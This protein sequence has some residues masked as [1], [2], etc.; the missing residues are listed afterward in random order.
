M[1]LALEGTP[2]HNNAT[3]GSSLTTGAFTTS[4]AA[5]VFIAVGSNF[6][7]ANSVSSISGG[8][9]TWSRR[10]TGGNAVQPIELWAAQ[11]GS[12]LSG[13][14]FTLTYSAAVQFTTVDVFA[15]SGQ[16]TSTI[17]DADAS[18]PVNSST[19]PISVSTSNANDF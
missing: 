14:Q 5:E 11:A 12:A 3:S 1:A 18:I 2:V 4:Q 9:L 15:V 16:D 8:G 6:A 10:T 7:S 17:W 19:D 13:V